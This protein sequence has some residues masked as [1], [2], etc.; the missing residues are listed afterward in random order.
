MEPKD[1]ILPISK[2]HLAMLLRISS[3]TLGLY[4]NYIW[5]DELKNLGYNK[6]KKVLSPLQLKYVQSQWKEL[7]FKRKY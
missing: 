5:F 4:L 7:D 1:Y 6:D 3:A 2:K